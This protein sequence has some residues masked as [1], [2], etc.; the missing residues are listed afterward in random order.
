MT[1]PAGR[2]LVCVLMEEARG[3]KGLPGSMF[4]SPLPCPL[5]PPLPEAA[6]PACRAGLGCRGALQGMGPVGRGRHQ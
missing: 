1:L 6:F 2:S 3:R 4:L 5:C